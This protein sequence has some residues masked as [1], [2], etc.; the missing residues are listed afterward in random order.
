LLSNAALF[1]DTNLHAFGSTRA[2][3]ITSKIAAVLIGA[4]LD[5]F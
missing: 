3:T 2:L 1:Y 5:S 4:A